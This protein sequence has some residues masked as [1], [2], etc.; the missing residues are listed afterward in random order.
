MICEMV[1]L[2]VIKYKHV[3]LFAL[4]TVGNLGCDVGYI[5]KGNLSIII[6]IKLIWLPFASFESECAWNHLCSQVV[7]CCLPQFH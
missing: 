6:I 4:D 7:I 3:P 2:L 5:G 1:E